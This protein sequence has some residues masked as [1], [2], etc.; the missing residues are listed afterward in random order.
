[1]AGF[2]IRGYGTCW[3]SVNA[4]EQDS[5][6]VTL[7]V[8]RVIRHRAPSFLSQL[9]ITLSFPFLDLSTLSSLKQQIYIA[10][11]ILS[12]PPAASAV[13]RC[14]LVLFFLTLQLLTETMPSMRR[15]MRDDR[16]QV[17]GHSEGNGATNGVHPIELDAVV[18]G[19]GYGA[20]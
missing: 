1:M 14:I 16:P 12:I 19:A 4:R 13:Y 17:N 5:R 6:I 10:A 18:I 2:C 3:P 15:N 20:D 11:R 7:S 8:V 9:S